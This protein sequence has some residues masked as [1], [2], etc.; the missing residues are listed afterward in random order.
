MSVKMITPVL[1]FL[2]F[3][4]ILAYMPVYNSWAVL[5]VL[6]SIAVIGFAMII[7]YMK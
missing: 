4:A 1:I 2:L 7:N 6:M 3:L 5:V